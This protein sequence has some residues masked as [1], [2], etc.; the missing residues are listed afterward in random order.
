VLDTAGRQAERRSVRTGRRNNS[1]I[2]VVDGLAAGERVILSSYAA[3]GNS[4]QL[5][6]TQ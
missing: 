3:F 1:Q 2:E 4:P 6:I 5:H